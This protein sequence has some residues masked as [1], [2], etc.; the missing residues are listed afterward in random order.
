MD[1]EAWR[2]FGKFYGTGGYVGEMW[3]DREFGG[4]DKVRVWV[5]LPSNATPKQP[6]LE[7]IVLFDNLSPSAR[8]PVA[9]KHKVFELPPLPESCDTFEI[10]S[11]N[12]NRSENRTSARLSAPFPTDDWTVGP[13]DRILW[14][15]ECSVYV[16]VRSSGNVL[17]LSG[18][19][20]DGTSV[21]SAN[22]TVPRVGQHQLFTP[23]YVVAA[24]GT[25]L[26]LP[27]MAV[28]L[29]LPA[30]LVEY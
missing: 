24:I 29:L 18:W 28:A 2:A 23:W 27:V 11:L 4:P 22:V 25:V 20:R 19:Y 1:P 10:R 26:A 7:W 30:A 21:C 12:Q 16:G 5:N 14:D 3:R 9:S 15:S 6:A 17:R 8:L 13:G